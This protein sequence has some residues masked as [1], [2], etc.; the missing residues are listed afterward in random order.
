MGA[1]FPDMTLCK[2]AYEVCHKADVLVIV[3]EWNE[4]RA[5]DFGRIKELLSEPIL[6]DLRNIYDPDA[7]RAEGF[8]YVSVG[9]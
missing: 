4:F 6:I 1:C 5:L 2:D 7:M 3:T 8:H 9:R